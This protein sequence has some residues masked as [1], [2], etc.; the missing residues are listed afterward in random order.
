MAKFIYQSKNW[1]YSSIFGILMKNWERF[2]LNC[3]V[4]NLNTKT[5]ETNLYFSSIM[6][7]TYVDNCYLYNVAKHNSGYQVTVVAFVSKEILSFSKLFIIYFYKQQEKI[8]RNVYFISLQNV[9]KYFLKEVRES[10]RK[11]ITLYMKKDIRR[12]HTEKQK[13]RRI[14][15][16]Y[17]AKKRKKKKKWKKEILNKNKRRY[18]Y[19]SKKKINM[20][21]S[22]KRT[23][24]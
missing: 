18:L 12:N 1:W 6:E 13:N 19:G 5:L 22:R 10:W 24:F 4:N 21:D 9:D 11:I 3:V 2:R 15:K 20:Q 23:K 7:M 8:K 14:R 17:K 16:L